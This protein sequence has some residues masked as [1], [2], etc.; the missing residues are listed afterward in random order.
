MKFV[1]TVGLMDDRLNANPTGSHTA[2]FDAA[3]L[4]KG[5]PEENAVRLAEYMVRDLFSLHRRR[6]AELLEKTGG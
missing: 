2:E 6:V 5:D 4:A 3:D 1:I